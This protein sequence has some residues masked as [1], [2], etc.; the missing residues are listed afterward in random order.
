MDLF[1]IQ[2]YYNAGL[3]HLLAH[4]GIGRQSLY[5]TYGNK[6]DLFLETLKRYDQ[7]VFG[8]LRETL[9]APGSPLTNIDNVLGLWKWLATREDARGCLATN[10]AVEVCR[11]NPEVAA[12][13]RGNF[14]R[15]ENAIHD[16]LERAVTHDELPTGT[17]TRALARFL[18]NTGHGIIAMGKMGTPPE[19]IDDVIRVARSAL[20]HPF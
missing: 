6:Q 12:I 8:R 14:F 17:N 11:S 3:Q 13:V 15:L 5:D 1:W 18:V 19:D 16:T 4:M 9:E 10:S 2:G 7:L 20:H